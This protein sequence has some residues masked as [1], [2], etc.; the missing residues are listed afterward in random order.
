[1]PAARQ[2]RRKREKI[3]GACIEKGNKENIDRGNRHENE[4]GEIER[5]REKVCV[6]EGREGGDSE[7]VLDVIWLVALPHCLQLA[8]ENHHGQHQNTMMLE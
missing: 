4:G 1:M 5:T 7:H 2:L 6:E 8:A 3:Q